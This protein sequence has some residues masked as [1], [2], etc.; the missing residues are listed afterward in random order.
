MLSLDIECAVGNDLA[1]DIVWIGLNS[2]GFISEK[3]WSVWVIHRYPIDIDHLFGPRLTFEGSI[4][5]ADHSL[6]FK[7]FLHLMVVIL[8]PFVIKL[9]L[10]YLLFDGRLA[11]LVCNKGGNRKWSLLIGKIDLDGV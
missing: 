6:S 8:K 4:I 1:E 3:N 11:T 9:L 5:H 7:T 2:Q 10:P